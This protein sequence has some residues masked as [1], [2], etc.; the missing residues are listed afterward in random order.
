MHHA[1]PLPADRLWQ[2]TLL[3]VLL[4]VGASYFINPASPFL[5]GHFI[6]PDDYAR[7]VQV[8]N[9]LDHPGG[10]L[11]G[12]YDFTQPRLD[13]GAAQPFVLDW[14][15]LPDLP[16]AAGVALLSPLF[17]RLGAAL[18]TGF[19]VPLLLLI[20]LI[21][22]WS[23][24]ARL[25]VR[26]SW[27]WLVPPMA[28]FFM[29]A[30]RE[31]MPMRVDHHGWQIILAGIAFT[32]LSHGIL[33][34]SVRWLCG[35]AA[36]HAL[37]VAVGA[38][39]MLWMLASLGWLAM[40]AVCRPNDVRNWPRLAAMFAGALT[41]CLLVLLPFVRA[42]GEW[43]VLQFFRLSLAQAA[44]AALAA[45]AL[46]LFRLAARG[47]R[48]IA[49]RF[50]IM[51]FIAALAGVAFFQL[52]PLAAGGVYAEMSADNTRLILDKVVEAKPL[53][54]RLGGLRFNIL[55]IAAYTPFITWNFLWPLLALS[56]A[57]R[58]CTRTRGRQQLLWQTFT[59]FLAISTGMTMFWQAR[60]DSFAHLFALPVMAWAG[61]A[62][63]HNYAKR[64]SGRTLHYKQLLLLLWLG[65]LPIL[66]IPA[67]ADGRPL[68]PNTLFYL[69]QMPPHPC[70]PGDLVK[71]LNDPKGLGAKQQNII[72]TMGA[73]P[74]FLFRTQ[75]GIYAAPYNVTGNSFVDE[76]LR[77]TDSEK[78]HAMA[79][80][81]GATL[82]LLC[83]N[84]VHS[85]WLPGDAAQAELEA[86][87]LRT[88]HKDVPASLQ[89]RR[90]LLGRMLT[91]D[92][93]PWLERIVLPFKTNYVLYRIKP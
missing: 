32:C 58:R 77:S 84:A 48:D 43:L 56:I 86:G 1:R 68:M 34:G 17:G 46:A 13:P 11:A 8:F 38:E 79:R 75:H 78:A 22:T 21:G 35:A 74:E 87:R 57:A 18:L 69:A 47:T 45:L 5:N 2:K 4:Y 25:L 26:R 37:G 61:V 9:W 83:V 54:E 15:R 20:V 39:S 23:E 3:I 91:L 55:G 93:P 65:P 67:I 52:V 64:F 50:V 29:P 27:L 44:F 60:V 76:F 72:T 31:V 59:W 82:A 36:F 80:E 16:L 73:G 10:V 88:L 28:L 81:R 62:C 24:M 19:F 92:A 51:A 42:P 70:A 63:W 12:W 85:H 14:S 30:V 66:I 7:F 40:L 49:V 41:L 89:A 71:V 33:R 90:Q 6:D 53:L